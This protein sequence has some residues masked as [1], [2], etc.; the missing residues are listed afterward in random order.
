MDK[1]EL[2]ESNIDNMSSNDFNFKEWY[3]NKVLREIYYF[4]E[5]KSNLIGLNYIIEENKEIGK[6]ISENYIFNQ[7][8]AT[9][10]VDEMNN[11]I[12]T[13]YELYQQAIERGDNLHKSQKIT[14]PIMFIQNWSN[15]IYDE[16]FK[17][18]EINSKEKLLKSYDI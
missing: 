10:Y 16:D 15:G 8:E 5:L 6:D 1:T 18:L 17:K 4:S 9:D 14:V 11:C 3:E 7:E 13:L 2:S 12:R